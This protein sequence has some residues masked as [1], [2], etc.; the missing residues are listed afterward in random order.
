[1]TQENIRAQAKLKGPGF[2]GYAYCAAMYCGNCGD[3]IIDSLT[4]PNSNTP[5]FL[6]SEIVPQP[7]FFAE[8]EFAEHCDQCGAYLYGPNV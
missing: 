8:S 3:A 5:E 7:A 4:L 6:D 1:M 2:K